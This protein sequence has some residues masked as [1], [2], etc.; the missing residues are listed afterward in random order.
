[1]L[2]L[3]G[4]SSSSTLPSMLGSS[5]LSLDR[6]VDLDLDAARAGTV[7][8]TLGTALTEFSG[9]LTGAGGCW[10]LGFKQSINSL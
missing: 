7:S 8:A 6:D 9:S 10:S 2:G 4:G 3:E 5:N 1:M